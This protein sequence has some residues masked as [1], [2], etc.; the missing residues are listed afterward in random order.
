MVHCCYE[1]YQQYF[2][3]NIETV[4][5]QHSM[6]GT[7]LYKMERTKENMYVIRTGDKTEPNAFVTLV[8]VLRF[9]ALDTIIVKL[10]MLRCYWWRKIP[11]QSGKHHLCSTG[12]LE[13]LPSWKI[14]QQNKNL[15][16]NGTQTYTVRGLG[17]HYCKFEI[18]YTTNM[19]L[20]M[21][22]TM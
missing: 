21:V 11:T 7:F 4:T 5:Y 18:N 15:T 19:C 13:D 22:P 3:F 20:N 1:H 16:Q 17:L 10:V 8:L 2:Y 14:L 12:W 6:N 9:M